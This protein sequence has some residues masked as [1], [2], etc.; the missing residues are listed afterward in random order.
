MAI[1]AANCPRQHTSGI[2]AELAKQFAADGFNLVL[3]A[4]NQT[5]LEE[6]AKTLRAAH[7][8]QVNVLPK[9]LSSA[10]APEEIFDALR[11]TPVSVLVNNAGFGAYGPFARSDLR[12]QTGMMQ[13]NMTALVELT[14]RFLQPMLARG[15][16]RILNVASTAAFQPGPMMNVYYAT[17]AF[18]YAFSYALAVELRGTGI[19]VTTLCPGTTHSEFFERARMRVSRTWPTMEARAVAETGYRGLMRGKRVVIPGM[20]NKI[21]AALARRAPAR[22]TTAV[23]ARIHRRAD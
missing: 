2:G 13:V 5:R 10:T 6:L 11:D 9:D 16:G 7:G 12:D 23:V 18:V 3:V 22:L 19:V 14:H 8:I 17:K 15:R 1:A 21:A 4:R 20:T